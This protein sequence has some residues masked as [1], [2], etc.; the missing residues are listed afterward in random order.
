LKIIQVF[1]ITILKGFRKAFTVSYVIIEMR[2][3]IWFI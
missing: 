2:F 1:S 3:S